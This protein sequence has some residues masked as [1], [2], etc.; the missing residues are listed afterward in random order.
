M[1]MLESEIIEH[2]KAKVDDERLRE[3]Y[4]ADSPTDYADKRL[5]ALTDDRWIAWKVLRQ[6]ANDNPN[7]PS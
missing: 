4:R 6:W 7:L 3:F 5:D 1:A 2:A